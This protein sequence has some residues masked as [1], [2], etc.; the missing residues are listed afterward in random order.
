[1]SVWLHV[2][3]K[4]HYLCCT[5]HCLRIAKDKCAI[6]PGYIKPRYFELLTILNTEII[7]L[8][9]LCKSIGKAHSMSTLNFTGCSIY[10]TAHRAFASGTSNDALQSLLARGDGLPSR[11]WASASSASTMKPRHK[12]NAGCAWGLSSIFCTHFP[13]HIAV[14]RWSQPKILQLHLSGM[15]RCRRHCVDQLYLN[16]I[17]RILYL[18][19]TGNRRSIL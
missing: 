6:D 12:V 10:W 1:M 13:R 3:V 14:M 9:I 19:C 17:E 18:Q 5:T 15:F 4:W 16:F 8:K 7:P 11:P 2:S